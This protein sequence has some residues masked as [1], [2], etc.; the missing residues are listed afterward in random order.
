MCSS[1]FSCWACCCLLLEVALS[2][3][4]AEGDSYIPHTMT[5]NIIAA[6]VG[7]AVGVVSASKAVG[8]S[9]LGPPAKGLPI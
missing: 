1:V 8:R 5:F 2:S 6:E 7:N 4:L 9:M 3:V